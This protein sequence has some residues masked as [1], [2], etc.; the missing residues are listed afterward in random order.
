MADAAPLQQA[1][2]LSREASTMA[3]YVSV[4]LGAALVAPGSPQQQ[5]SSPSRGRVRLSV[6]F[7]AS[8][9]AVTKNVLSRRHRDDERCVAGLVLRFSTAGAGSGAVGRSG[10]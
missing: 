7:V 5:Q 6:L 3:L 10:S 8:V 2:E 9:I 1:Q 4:C